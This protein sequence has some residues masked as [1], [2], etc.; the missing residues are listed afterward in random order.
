MT[1]TDS[2]LLE[3]IIVAIYRNSCDCR[4]QEIR[5]ILLRI[6]LDNDIQHRF[7]LSG[8]FFAQFN[9]RNEAVR[10]QVNLSEFENVE[11]GIICVICI[12]PMEYFELYRLH[13]KTN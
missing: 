10:K 2:G 5:D 8:K 7:N 9:K 12:N 11:H 13:Y 3:F 6:F 1:D 4:E